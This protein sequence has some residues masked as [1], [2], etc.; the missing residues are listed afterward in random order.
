[1]DQMT[2]AL[3]GLPP[4]W[5][6]ALEM[7]ADAERFGLELWVGDHMRGTKDPELAMLE[8][9]AVLSAW[10]AVTRDVRL[11]MGV[12]NVS[13]NSP[14]V[15]AKRLTTIDHISGGRVTLGI[16]AGVFGVD[17]HMAGVWVESNAERVQRVAEF[18]ESID[19]L[20][21]GEIDAFE[22]THFTFADAY[23]RPLP[24]Q[25][26]RPPIM[27]AAAKPKMM[28]LAARFADTWD[29]FGALWRPAN[30]VIDGLA[31]QAK[32]F[33]VLCHEE[34][35]DPASVR[36]SVDLYMPIN[37]WRS[38]AT[39]QSLVE[40]CYGLGFTEF[41]F[42]TP[43]TKDRDVFEEVCTEVIPSYRHG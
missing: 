31:E 17:E 4:S 14:G 22:G 37:P 11:G 21:R 12:V 23:V 13:Y 42:M 35:R 9:W 18:T 25:H 27:I 26:P 29:T 41:H 15:V 24:I 40:Q 28:R 16:G 8:G 19:G 7:A 10:A 1:M 36:R 3:M 5:P 39:F 2:F 38:R 20:L 34:G 30:E 6:A 32:A 43:P 33:D